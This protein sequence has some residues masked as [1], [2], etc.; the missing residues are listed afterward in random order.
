MKRR[1]LFTILSLSIAT[2]AGSAAIACSQ[3]PTPTNINAQTIIDSLPSE[4]K[5]NIDNQE[6]DKL[7]EK[8]QNL[9]TDLQ[10][11]FLNLLDETN[12]QT[13][14]NALK[15]GYKISKITLAT[16]DKSS[17]SLQIYLSVS[18]AEDV[19]NKTIKIV[20]LKQ[21]SSQNPPSTKVPDQPEKGKP[22]TGASPSDNPE[23]PPKNGDP[24]KSKP[25]K[26]ADPGAVNS[27]PPTD[28]TPPNP[29][30]TGQPEKPI[31][32]PKPPDKPYV[33]VFETD[34]R[35]FQ[36]YQINTQLHTDQ[37]EKNDYIFDI[38]S[39]GSKKTATRS[40][41]WSVQNEA[42]KGKLNNNDFLKAI[43]NLDAPEWNPNQNTYTMAKKQKD[44]LL[45]N[46]F[47]I[48][49]DQNYDQSYNFWFNQKLIAHRSIEHL[50]SASAKVDID[51]IAEA[52]LP[53]EPSEQVK[54]DAVAMENSELK[55]N[56][57]SL[58]YLVTHNE[59]GQNPKMFA[60]KLLTLS[61]DIRLNKKTVLSDHI[62]L[63]NISEDEK[64]YKLFEKVDSD[65]SDIMFYAEK[66]DNKTGNMILYVSYKKNGSSKS[67]KIELNKQNSELKSD[68]DFIKYVND[69]S[70]SIAW[71]YAGWFDE[72]DQYDD[73]KND[74]WKNLHSIF[75]QRISGFKDVPESYKASK[76]SSYFGQSNTSGVKWTRL[77]GSGGT[78]WVVDKII[79]PSL[80]QGQHAFVVA[81]NKH[82]IDIGQ[83]AGTT[84]SRF[85]NGF[86]FENEHLS[87]EVDLLTYVKRFPW[88]NEKYAS[89]NKQNYQELFKDQPDKIELIK[90]RIKLNEQAIVTNRKIMNRQSSWLKNSGFTSFTW[91]RFEPDDY[92]KTDPIDSKHIHNL[93]EAQ[94]NQLP[95]RH[96]LPLDVVG[97]SGKLFKDNNYTE[98]NATDES[99]SW[100]T[101]TRKNFINSIIYNPQ[102]SAGHVYRASDEQ[103]D[104]RLGGGLKREETNNYYT[105]QLL[106]PDLVLIK[107]IFKEEDLKKYWKALYEIV[108]KSEEEQKKWFNGIDLNP[109]T[110]ERVN[111]YMA[112][113]PAS[114]DENDRIFSY[115]TPE[116]AATSTLRERF[117]TQGVSENISQT[118]FADWDEIAFKKYYA[119]YDLG[120][121]FNEANIPVFPASKIISNKENGLFS[122]TPRVATESLYS[123]DQVHPGN[124][125]T[126]VIDANFKNYAIIFSYVPGLVNGGAKSLAHHFVQ[127]DPYARSNVLENQRPNVRLEL[128]EM[129]KK[130]NIKTL[131]LNPEK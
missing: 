31:N 113:Y 65:I 125:G 32:Q 17:A 46:G 61:D 49:S 29:P 87:G 11:T 42:V 21:T 71:K 36:G 57:N 127:Q 43:P 80:P 104:S 106:G 9:G 51:K 115:R 16:A 126:M 70:F 53:L 93:T 120:G 102:F 26:T 111:S 30:V 58:K 76:F 89:I 129:L 74:T 88:Y 52:P 98:L 85:F 5:T 118:F 128:I 48:N 25:P 64:S 117:L 47:N 108:H 107:M 91:N 10:A 123:G 124:S 68:Y 45:A 103:G 54:K 112:G 105:H 84:T 28:V 77:S 94:K 3:Q 121:K 24:E 79:D 13:F 34:L 67:F 90:D 131:N 40:N 101:D 78:G 86:T 37:P 97:F 35:K 50:I 41:E 73:D 59:M 122:V 27:K 6:L 15:D 44:E 75:K 7:K 4:V 96:Q 14:A 119:P 83:F 12:K 82:V 55:F 66:V 110:D 19:K 95:I 60:W 20:D 56:L 69:R 114:G 63:N 38:Y 8:L 116:K 100:L 2:F 72:N 18:N 130:K 92:T 33:Q 62:Y 23:E 99:P 109:Y 39:E 1:K 22:P 81:T